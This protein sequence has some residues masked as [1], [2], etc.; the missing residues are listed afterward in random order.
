MSTTLPDKTGANSLTDANTTGGQ[1]KTNL[2]NLRDFIADLFGTSTA[3]LRTV[4]EAFRLVEP[5][6]LANL[7]LTF[8]VGSSALTIAA[9][10]RAGATASATDPILVGQRS[11]TAGNGD[12]NLRAVTGAL[13]LVVSSGST[14][15]L[16]NGDST[17]LYVYLLDYSSGTPELAISQAWLG[18]SGIVTTVAEGGAG[19]ADSASAV[20]SASARTSVPFR[21]I[22]RLKA[23]QT[24]AGT[25]AAVPTECLLWPFD[26][27]GTSAAAQADVDA[28][29]DTAK[30]ISSALNRTSLKTLT[31]STSG[32][33]VDFSSIPA[34]VRRID[35]GFAGVSTSGSSLV[36]VRLGTGGTPETSG[37]AGASGETSAS[38]AGT[39]NFTAGFDINDVGVAAS[40]RHGLLTLVLMDPA[41]NLWAISGNVGRSDTT[42]CVL[43]G[44]T[45]AL[46][47][48]LDMV[49]I[50]TVNGTDTFDAGSINIAYSK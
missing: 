18:P 11:A 39:I 7:S 44:G 3:A 28:G 1:Q 5:G 38:G 29:T 42:V 2:G 37:Y 34:G 19:A 12:F 25:W 36:R 45:K 33:S 32:T 26:P 49:R 23:P 16:A 14:L 17:P 21:A 22:A 50:T 30:F 35:I 24:T 27:P 9:K 31:A 8:A 15:G 43:I 10:T 48:V 47:G 6:K 40:V 13:S 46:A 4:W 41:T 20:Y